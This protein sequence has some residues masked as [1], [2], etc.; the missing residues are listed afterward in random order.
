MAYNVTLS[1][2]QRKILTEALLGLDHSLLVGTDPISGETLQTEATILLGHLLELPRYE[3]E[4]PG[5]LLDIALCPQED[6]SMHLKTRA[7]MAA[8]GLESGVRMTMYAKMQ[9]AAQKFGL[10]FDGEPETPALLFPKVTT[11][12]GPGT[13]MICAEGSSVLLDIEDDDQSPMYC[14]MTEHFGARE[15]S[16]QARLIYKTMQVD[17]QAALTLMIDTLTYLFGDGA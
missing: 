9:V 8:L 16:E 4:T 1:E 7:A 11:K 14:S 10:E 6:A 2:T 15:A 12:D 13:P 5:A 3:D 17:D